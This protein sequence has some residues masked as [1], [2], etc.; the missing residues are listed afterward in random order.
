MSQMAASKNTW[1]GSVRFM[2]HRKHRKHRKHRIQRRCSWL[3]HICTHTHTHI[4]SIH[5]TICP[6]QQF[7]RSTEN[8]DV[9]MYI[10]SSN[11]SG[12]LVSN[13]IWLLL[14]FDWHFNW[15]SLHCFFF[16]FGIGISSFN[17]IFRIFFL[18]FRSNY[19]K[20]IHVEKAIGAGSSVYF[21]SRLRSYRIRRSLSCFNSTSS[22]LVFI[23]EIPL[24][25]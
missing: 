8:A 2:Q 1:N 18:L 4:E 11:R 24:L 12:V 25:L 20:I 21:V 3:P 15:L 16:L 5:C 6:R 10:F 23:Y 19:Q 17:G 22:D 13:E 9:V 7:V 14:L